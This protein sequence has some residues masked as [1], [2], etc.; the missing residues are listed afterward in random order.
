MATV[1]SRNDDQ[2]VRIGWQVRVR[3]KGYPQQVKTFRTKVEAERCART[4]ESEMARGAWLDRSEAERTTIGELL[5]RYAR[6]V[7]AERKHCTPELSRLNTLKEHF[8]ST[9]VARLASSAIAEFRNRRLKEQGRGGKSVSGQIVKYE[10]GLLLRVLKKAEREWGIALPLGLPTEKVQAPKL[11]QARDRQLQDDEGD[12]LL[13]ECGKARHPWL[14]PV[15]LFSIETA[16][17]AGEILQ[18]KR[19]D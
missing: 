1:T 14:L 4:T 16:M 6:E 12:R 17:R 5:D 7:L 8:A 3:K 18:T 9:S 15:V 13:A 11:P 19:N 10:L 2:G